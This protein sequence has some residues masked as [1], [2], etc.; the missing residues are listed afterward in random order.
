M[1][2]AQARVENRPIPVPPDPAHITALV[3]SSIKPGASV[4]LAFNEG[5]LTVF[6]DRL[7]D[8]TI[9]IG[10]TTRSS[11]SAVAGPL[12]EDL[13]FFKAVEE[14]GKVYFLWTSALRGLSDNREYA[15]E[16][17]LEALKILQTAPRSS[18]IS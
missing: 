2:E 4:F 6:L 13:G 18:Y 14:D 17:L 15:E 7:G 11:M 1:T 5:M 8:W 12:L 3:D 16:K 10:L 9:S